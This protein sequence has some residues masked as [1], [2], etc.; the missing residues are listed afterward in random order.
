MYEK[1]MDEDLHCG[2]R[3]A[4]KIFGG[5]W[6]M[7]IL[8]AINKGAT[9]PAEIQKVIGIAS[10][11][12]IEI[13]LAELLA[14]GVTEK[15]G[16]NYYPKK[17]EYRIT[18][19]GYTILPLLYQIDKWG[20]THGAFVRERQSELNQQEVMLQENASTNA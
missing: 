17:S 11:R 1:K 15:T 6:K 5:K 7:C 13:Q 14:Y 12:V 16:G 2:L 19:F 9:R 8:D 4:F 10:I 3:V 20:T 18:S